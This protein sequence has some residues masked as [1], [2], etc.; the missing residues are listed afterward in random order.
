M[1]A[2]LRASNASVATGD[3]DRDLGCFLNRSESGL[4][5]EL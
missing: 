1:K 2:F 5:M 3:Q 4:V